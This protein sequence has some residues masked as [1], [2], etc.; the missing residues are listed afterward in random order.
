[1]S[2]EDAFE[3]LKSGDFKTAVPL[4]ETAARETEYTS[5]IINH[6]YTLALHH[7]G[8]KSRLADVAF[9]VGNLLVPDDPGSAMDYF[10]RALF[11]GLDS[12]RV[13]RI[14]EIHEK[15]AV[16]RPGAHLESPVRKVAHVLGCVLQGHAPTQYVKM[17]CSS[18]QSQ[19]IESSVF[20][21]EWAASW[22]FNPAGV[23]QSQNVGISTT[24][25]SV[26][27]D[28][29]E[30][31]EKVA[32]AVRASGAQ[33]A[34][35]HASL[36]EQ[37]TTRVAAMRPTPIQINVNH[38]SEMDADLFDGHI[39]LFKN[40]LERTR[41]GSHPAEWIPLASDVEE[42]LNAREPVTRRSLG[43]ESASSVS[44]TF[45][46]LSKVAGS[47]YLKML[48]EILRRFPKHFHL[49]AGAGEVKTIRAALHAEGVLPRVRFLGQMSDVTPLLGAV[50][51]YLA[52]FP[53]SGE[54]S[55]LEAMGAGKPVV[56]LRY[57]PDSHYNSGAELVGIPELIAPGEADYVE[58]AD[59]LIR[60]A[61]HRAKYS[62]VIR[63]R[64]RAE[65]RPSKL[66]ERYREFL[67]RL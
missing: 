41:Y 58:L 45:G 62:D 29:P 64:F 24:V 55:I 38:G 26:E 20:T 61:D 9:R 21:T 2:Y 37:L 5:D 47:G 51:V 22:F 59:R 44:A 33:V 4:L 3:A 17:L 63:D 25:A 12:A 52:S 56:V 23:Q 34:F 15:W 66:G 53:H 57:P 65:F 28:F 16:P 40:A 32:A 39:H 18:L 11:A 14:G 60:N 1:M 27:G 30:R 7:A 19:G 10:Q 6:A 50:D 13:R 31:A 42:R 54:H 43:I 35:Y 46:N 49:F 8:E 36:T 48:T 67:E